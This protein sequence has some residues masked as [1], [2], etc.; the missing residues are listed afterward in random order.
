MERIFK[1]FSDENDYILDMYGGSGNVAKAINNINRFFYTFEIG[2][3]TEKEE[4]EN[5]KFILK[6]LNYIQNKEIVYE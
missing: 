2:T 4:K 6:N 1:L 5:G 3:L